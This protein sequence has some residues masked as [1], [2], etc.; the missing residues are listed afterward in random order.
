MVGWAT[1]EITCC[2]I[3]GSIE[4]GISCSSL[5]RIGG[6]NGDGRGGDHFFCSFFQ[7]VVVERTTREDEEEAE[8]NIV[9][10]K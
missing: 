8:L 4:E 1:S 3:P 7:S 6:R 2:A 5:T 9:I 10:R